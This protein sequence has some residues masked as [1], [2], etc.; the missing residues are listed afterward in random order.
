[1]LAVPGAHR[2]AHCGAG[3]SRLFL[4]VAQ[5][6]ENLKSFV[7][8]GCFVILVR[9]RAWRRHG[10]IL[11]YVSIYD[12]EFDDADEFD[13]ADFAD[14]PLPPRASRTSRIAMLAAITAVVAVVATGLVIG[15][16]NGADD[17][18]PATGPTP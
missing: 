16:G 7:R 17:S 8:V 3:G 13:E 4:E 14:R 9:V 2:S 5:R 6:T 10:R 11:A 12:D 15:G 18:P 1:M